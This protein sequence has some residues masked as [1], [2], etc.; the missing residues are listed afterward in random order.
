MR[1]HCVLSVG[2]IK[3]HELILISPLKVRKRNP[4]LNPG[5][6]STHP[7]EL[8]CKLLD[9]MAKDYGHPKLTLAY[10]VFMRTG[11]TPLCS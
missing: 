2:D 1:L 3:H 9:L 5:M 10:L 7:E 8:G 11:T 6:S 4:H